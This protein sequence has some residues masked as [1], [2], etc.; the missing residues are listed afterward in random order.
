VR[1]EEK[2][3]TEDQVHHGVSS[4]LGQEGFFRAAYAALRVAIKKVIS[5]GSGS[6]GDPLYHLPAA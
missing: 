2:D 1:A 6:S 3:Q 4:I 5:P